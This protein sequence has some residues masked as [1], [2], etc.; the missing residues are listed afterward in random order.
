MEIRKGQLF[1]LPGFVNCRG[2]GL[3]FRKDLQNISQ[4][5]EVYEFI[6]DSVQRLIDEE[7]LRK[8]YYHRLADQIESAVPERG[9]LLE[10]G[11]GCGGLLTE[12]GARG[13]FIEGMEPSPI[14]AEIAEKQT[15]SRGIIHQ[16]AFQEGIGSLPSEPY[17]VVIA[18]DVIEHLIDPWVFIQKVAEILMD[19]GSLI[20]QTPNVNSLRRIIQGSAWEQFKPDE[21]PLL[22]SAQ[23]LTTLLTQA[24][25]R[26]ST[27][28]TLSGSAV[29]SPM[30]GRLLGGF[31]K[32]INSFHGGNAL[33][34]VSR[35]VCS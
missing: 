15:G 20:L 29:E 14:F 28:E 1:S 10:I 5:N 2:C 7:P 26:V 6:S 17:Q 13:W 18:I 34:S 3:F 11:S 31:Q 25:F 9:K 30:R 8:P 19:G 12:L 24:G 22:Y 4:P 35:K 16:Q 23:A 21:H 33:W 27:M 32:I